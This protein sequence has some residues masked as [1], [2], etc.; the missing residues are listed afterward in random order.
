MG[1]EGAYQVAQWKTYLIFMALSHIA[2]C[3]NIFG[4]RILGKWNEGACEWRQSIVCRKRRDV[5]FLIPTLFSILVRRT[6]SR[7]CRCTSRNF[8]EEYR[9]I[10]LHRLPEHDRLP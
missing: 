2:I 6:L 4:F 3:L 8:R 7:Y 1:S 10:R 5:I 9:Q